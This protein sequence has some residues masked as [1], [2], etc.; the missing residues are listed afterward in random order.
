MIYFPI[1]A[2]LSNEQKK[3][4]IEADK[5]LQ[6][7]EA[8]YKHHG[9]SGYHNLDFGKAPEIELPFN[10]NYNKITLTAVPANKTIPPHTDGNYG[11]NTVIIFPISPDKEHYAPCIADNK[12]IPYMD[13]Y[14]FNTQIEHT[15][16]NNNNRRLSLQLWLDISIEQALEE[17]KGLFIT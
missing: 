13:C 9:K 11:R 5:D 17:A 15:V 6:A 2:S 8:Y 16:V 3:L 14:A 10:I 12:E 4:L 7:K 1:N